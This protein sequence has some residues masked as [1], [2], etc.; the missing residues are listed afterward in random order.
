MYDRNAAAMALSLTCLL[1][2]SWLLGF[3][4]YA[5]TIVFAYMFTIVNGLQGVA[6]FLFRC[7][8]NDE[9]RTNLFDRWKRHRKNRV[10]LSIQSF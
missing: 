10:I 2:L 1:G 7:L 8:L 5:E 9:V 4:M 6:I 3:L